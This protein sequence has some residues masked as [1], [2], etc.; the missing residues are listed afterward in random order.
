MDERMVVPAM[1]YGAKNC[2]LR[3]EKRHKFDV[4][5][6]RSLRC[7]CGVK[8]IGRLRNEDVSRRNDVK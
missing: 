2:G 7:M 6:N 3:K 8:K 4:L 5:E 1:I